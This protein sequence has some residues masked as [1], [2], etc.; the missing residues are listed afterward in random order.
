MLQGDKVSPLCFI[1]ALERNFQTRNPRQAV[2]KLERNDDDT[3]LDENAEAAQERLSLPSPAANCERGLN[4]A[5]H[6]SFVQHVQK[7]QRVTRTA[8]KD[9]EKM[10]FLLVTALT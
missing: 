4:V 9:V 5:G 10:D 3:V 2:N 6:K 8:E 1:I 7:A